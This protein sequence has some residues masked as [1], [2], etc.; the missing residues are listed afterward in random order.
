MD[1]NNNNSIIVFGI[2]GSS[3]DRYTVPNLKWK[4]VYLYGRLPSSCAVKGCGGCFEATAH[5]M[6]DDGRRSDNWFLVPQCA[7]HNNHTR[8]GVRVA[9]RSNARLISLREVREVDE[10]TARRVKERFRGNYDY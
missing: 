6:L 8:N 1:Y 4:F 5:V 7:Q 3:I 9:L 10:A 2:D